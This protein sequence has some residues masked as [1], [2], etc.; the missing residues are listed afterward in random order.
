[1]MMMVGSLTGRCCCE[2]A[3]VD[4]G[5]G[6]GVVDDVEAE[7]SVAGNVAAAAAVAKDENR[8]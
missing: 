4:I 1:M 5:G 6:V 8:N 3:G 7:S 2:D